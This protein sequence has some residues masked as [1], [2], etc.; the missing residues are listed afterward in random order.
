MFWV[1]EDED[2]EKDDGEFSEFDKF[3]CKKKNV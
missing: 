2:G 1:D 3:G